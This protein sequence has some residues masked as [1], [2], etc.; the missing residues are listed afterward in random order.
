MTTTEEKVDRIMKLLK[1]KGYKYTDKR[2]SM[3]KLLVTEDRYI[4][5]KLS[6]RLLVKC[7][8]DLVLIQ[9]IEI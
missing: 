8:L 1:E 6:L 9:S 4:N 3:V 5:A 7:I 2:K